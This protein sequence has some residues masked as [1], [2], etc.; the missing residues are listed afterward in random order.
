M[1]GI[2]QDQSQPKLIIVF[3]KFIVKLLVKAVV[4]QNKLIFFV[5]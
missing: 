1:C 4:K 3:Y 5:I 2:V